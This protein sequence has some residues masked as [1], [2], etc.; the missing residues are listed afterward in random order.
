[1]RLNKIFLTKIEKK[2]LTQSQPHNK[3]QVRHTFQK[4]EKVIQIAHCWKL[5]KI[6][7]TLIHRIFFFWVI[8]KKIICHAKQILDSIWSCYFNVRLRKKFERIDILVH[9]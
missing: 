4:T 8:T 3:L 6:A 7:Y 2:N 5:S 1:M 9:I